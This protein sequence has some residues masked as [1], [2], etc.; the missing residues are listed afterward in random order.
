VLVA[1]GVVAAVAGWH[2]AARSIVLAE[3]LPYL[4]SGGLIGVALIFLGSLAYFGHAHTIEIRDARARE[5]AEERRHRE[6][7]AAL[8]RST[9][10]RNGAD[11]D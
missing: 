5:R 6:V 3:Q 11:V 9:T 8:R 10:A 7:L 1:A 4:I 2:G